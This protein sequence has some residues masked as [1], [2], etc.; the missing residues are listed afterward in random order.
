MRWGLDGRDSPEDIAVLYTW[1]GN[2]EIF[3]RGVGQ[4][5]SPAAR[6]MYRFFVR[7]MRIKRS[8]IVGYSGT[9]LLL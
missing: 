1:D 2:V 9:H 5:S 7:G 6:M 4:D 3:Y 8:F